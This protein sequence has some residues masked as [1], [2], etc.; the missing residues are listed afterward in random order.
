MNLTKYKLKTLLL[1][2]FGAIISFTIVLLFI[3]SVYTNRLANVSESLLHHPLVVSNAVR[4]IEINIYAM[5]LELEYLVLRDAHNDLVKVSRTLDSLER[6]T[7]EKFNIVKQS[8]LGNPKD[9]ENTYQSFMNWRSTRSEIILCIQKNEHS[10]AI[11]KLNDA[12]QKNISELFLKTRKMIEFASNKASDFHKSSVQI[13][14]S[15]YRTLIF[16]SLLLISLSILASIVITRII[17]IPI[18]KIIKDII[19]ISKQNFNVDIDFKGNHHLLL[20]ESS[21][22]KLEELS[23]ELVKEYNNKSAL[24]QEIEQSQKALIYI[25]ED[26]NEIKAE[27]EKTVLRL[28]YSN[29]EL[30][31]FVYSI[32]HDLRAPLR[33]IM[34]FSEIISKRYADRLNEEGLKYFGYVLEASRNMANLIEDLIR[35]SR[36]AKNPVAKESVNLNEIIDTVKKNLFQ[37]ITDK[38]AQLIVPENLPEVKGDRA[39]LGQIYANLIQNAIMYSR[40]NTRP[41]VVLSVDEDENSFILK[42]KDNGQGIPKE[43]QEKVFNIFQRL[44]S[45]EDY[46]G[47][48][49]GLAIVKKAV[50][51]LDGSVYVESE[52]NVGSTFFISLPK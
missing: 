35:F 24:Q 13:R 51:A 10:K 16:F 2:G 50:M 11:L 41:E 32:S 15:I 18:T 12:N 20:L 6:N 43:H 9:V 19:R 31:S 26:V 1:L 29:N 7:L 30:E 4:D 14:N 17:T 21:V 42:V 52:V 3:I 23:I 34:G 44:H 22:K 49:I 8:F 36:L 39:L 47:T 45:N 33:S 37:D 40:I 25:V 27:L 28:S 48:G 5:N 46:P 38:D